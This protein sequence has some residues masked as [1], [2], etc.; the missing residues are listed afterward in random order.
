MKRNFIAPPVSAWAVY[1][2]MANP[3]PG[4]SSSVRSVSVSWNSFRHPE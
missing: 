1:P 2:V 4:M 3:E